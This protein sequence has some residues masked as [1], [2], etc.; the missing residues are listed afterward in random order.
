MAKIKILQFSRTGLLLGA[1]YVGM[2]ITCVIWAQFI[3]DPKGKYIILQLPVVLQHGL[4][5][6][7]DA[8]WILKGMTWTGVYLLLG[9]PVLVFLVILGN[10]YENIVKKVIG[11]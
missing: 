5:F 11:R 10:I 1:L 4:L 6:A 3:T 2:I 8:T 9:I 7:I